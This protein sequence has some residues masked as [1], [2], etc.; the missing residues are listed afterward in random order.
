[1]LIKRKQRRVSDA[2]PCKLDGNCRSSMYLR[3]SALQNIPRSFWL[4][5]AL[6]ARYKTDKTLSFSPLATVAKHLAKANDLM[7]PLDRLLQARLAFIGINF[8]SIIPIWLSI[9]E[10]FPC[11]WPWR[12]VIIMSSLPV[13]ICQQSGLSSRIGVDGSNSYSPALTSLRHS[14]SKNLFLGIQSALPFLPQCSKWG[15][16][17]HP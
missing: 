6:P 13:I 9:L 11:L 12:N 10:A 2:C 15:P 14:C 8:F 1:M 5:A 17:I 3:D 4:D 7:I 16:M